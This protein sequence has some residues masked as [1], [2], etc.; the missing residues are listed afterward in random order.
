LS[1]SNS[2][3]LN[4][5]IDEKLPGRPT[6]QRREVIIA[7]EA[8]ELFSRDI[9]ECIKALWGDIDFAS[10]LVVEPER[11]YADADQTIRVYCDM[12]TGKWWWC[13]Q[14]SHIVFSNAYEPFQIMTL[15]GTRGPD[16]KKGMHHNSHNHFFR[17]NT[18]Y[19]VSWKVCL[20]SL[21]DDRQ[22]S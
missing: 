11:H 19:F 17:Q 12:N 20:S 5:I 22:S 13:T 21:Y 1:Y 7:N 10:H 4:K 14:V 8:F 9:V 2:N 15:E 3:E 18:T 16:G 6:F